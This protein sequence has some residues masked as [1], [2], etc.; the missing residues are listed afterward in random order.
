MAEA[1]KLE[2]HSSQPSP[3]TK[4]NTVLLDAHQRFEIK[5]NLL[6]LY[7]FLTLTNYIVD[8]TIEIYIKH[9][10]LIL[11]PQV[12]LS[13]VTQ[14]LNKAKVVN[15]SLFSKNPKWEMLTIK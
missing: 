13:K 14:L 10:N 3:H 6:V 1:S 15:F 9:L 11:S 7:L 8:I 5:F 2:A 4:P 12:I